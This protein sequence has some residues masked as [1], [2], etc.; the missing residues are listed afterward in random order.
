[1]VKVGNVGILCQLPGLAWD[2]NNVPASVE[3]LWLYPSISIY[4]Q[5]IHIADHFT[6]STTRKSC[7]HTSTTSTFDTKKPLLELPFGRDRYGGWNKWLLFQ[8]PRSSYNW[9]TGGHKIFHMW[10]QLQLVTNIGIWSGR[11]KSG[12]ASVTPL[13]IWFVKWDNVLLGHFRFWSSSFSFIFFFGCLRFW[14]SS[15]L[16]EVVVKRRVHVNYK[17]IL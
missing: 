16:G 11:K 2:C 6:T 14:S 12:D 9:T 1:M 17:S 13:P 10:V 15:F 4:N 5:I 3:P 7:G 8:W